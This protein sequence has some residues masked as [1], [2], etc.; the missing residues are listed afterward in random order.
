MRLHIVFV[1]V[2]KRLCVARSSATEF[3]LLE[4]GTPT[5]A[6]AGDVLVANVGGAATLEAFNESRGSLLQM[7]MLQHFTRVDDAIRA[8]R[9]HQSKR[10]R[11]ERL[12]SGGLFR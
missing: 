3:H 9:Q 1:D 5:A 10:S 4:M 2:D 11:L 8:A 6:R 7:R 12:L